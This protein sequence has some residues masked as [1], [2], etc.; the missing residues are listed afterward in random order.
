TAGAVITY[1][2]RTR[3]L[4]GPLKLEVLDEK[5]NL[6]DTIPATKHRG[7]NRVAWSMQV[8]PPR[9][10]RAATIA[11]AGTQGPRVVPGMY[12]LRLTKGTQ[13]IETKFP[14]VLDRRAK[15][16]LAGRQEHF[17][18]AMRAHELFDQMSDLVDRIDAAKVKADPAL[19]AKLD[20]VKKKIV[21][22]K[23]GGAITG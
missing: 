2:Q 21:A 12:T 15:W 1:Y 10:P 19:V 11:F 4:Y 9:V 23:E 18:A 13:V 8:K 20:A 5:G 16:D 7:I 17:A 6:I 3:H 22:T 14:I